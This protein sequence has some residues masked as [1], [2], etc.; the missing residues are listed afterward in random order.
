MHT[1]KFSKPTCSECVVQ[2]LLDPSQTKPQ[3]SSE[4]CGSES[5]LLG[6]PDLCIYILNVLKLACVIHYSLMLIWLRR[7]LCC[8]PSSVVCWPLKQQH[9]S[10]K[11]TL[12]IKTECYN[13]NWEEDRG[14]SYPLFLIVYFQH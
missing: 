3:H 13:S 9:T 4:D 7:Q 12:S 1:I 5:L 6:V 2:H 10:M 14:H 8:Q 11:S